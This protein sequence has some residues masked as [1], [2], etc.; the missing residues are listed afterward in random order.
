MGGDVTFILAATGTYRRQARMREGDKE[1]LIQGSQ[2]MAI[3]LGRPFD[4]VYEEQ[5]EI[6]FED[7]RSFSTE[8]VD[9]DDDDEG[10]YSGLGS[11]AAAGWE[12]AGLDA[13]Q[14]LTARQQELARVA[15]DLGEQFKWSS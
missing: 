3:R 5:K 11:L 9:P 7:L 14:P 2:A 12:I 6:W 13:G 15:A 10:S 8:W 1:A 4:E